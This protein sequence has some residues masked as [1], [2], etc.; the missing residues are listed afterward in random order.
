MRYRRWGRQMR[1]LVRR[2]YRSFD[3]PLS[4][5]SMTG[6]NAVHV[7][8]G[9]HPAEWKAI[10]T[11]SMPSSSRKRRR[12]SLAGSQVRIISDSLD[13]K[14]FMRAAGRRRSSK[15][16]SRRL[17]KSETAGP[18]RSTVQEPR[19]PRAGV[20]LE[21]TKPF[22]PTSIISAS[23]STF[24]YLTSASSLHAATNCSRSRRPWNRGKIGAS[25]TH[26][27]KL[28]HAFP[29]AEVADVQF[30]VFGMRRPCRPQP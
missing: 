23:F 16:P 29:V 3:P 6:R 15:P 8:S 14:R 26:M 24:K 28:F 22:V 4:M 11:Y 12:S 20:E 27:G 7:L 1:S 30:L 19:R 2:S 10:S 21:G 13:S 17:T 18:I 5:K 25:T 9:A